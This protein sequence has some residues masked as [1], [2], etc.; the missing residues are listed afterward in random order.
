MG[1][2][3]KYDADVR[4]ALN[5]AR[6]E[7]QKLRHRLIGSEHLLQGIFRLQDPL[8]EGLFA[9]LH[10]SV[11]GVA[12][13][14]DFVIGRGNKAILSEPSLS[15]SARAVLA[16]AE[17][18]AAWQQHDLVKVEHLFL[19]LLEERNGIAAGVLESFGVYFDIARTQL[20]TLAGGGYERLVL[21]TR[22]H[23]RSNTTPVLNQ[24]S[25]DLTIAA[26]EGLIDPLIGRDEELTRIIQILSRR[27][28]NNPALIGPAGVGKTVIAEGLALRI[29]Q[30][31]VPDHLLHSRVVSLD[32]GL[33][34]VGTRFR[35]DFE[36]RLKRIVQEIIASPGLILFIDELHTLVQT[37]V[38]EGSIDAANLFKPMLARGEIRCMGATTLDEYR[39]SVEADPALERRFQPVSIRETNTSETLSIL[40]GLRSRYENFH[41][42]TITD[43]ALDAAIKMSDRYISH[44]CQP[45]KALDLIDEAAARVCVQHSAASG[46]ACQLR[47]ALIRVRR[48]KEQMVGKHNFAQASFLLKQER[49]IRQELWQKE[50]EWYERSEAQRPVVNIHAI[51]D[52]VAMST[53]IPVTQIAGEERQRLLQLEEMLQRR[54]VG[55]EEAIQAVARA[56][57][58]AR[59]QM[60]DARRP[61]GS[62]I[63]VGPT[64]VGKTELARAL[65]ASLFDN[66]NALLKFDMSEFMESHHA[67]RLIGAPPG[68]IG[69]D[70]AGQLTEAVRRRP[71]CVVLFD[72]IEKAH[73]K[74]FDLL[75]QIL[76]EGQL[77]DSQGRVVDF[78][79]TIIILTSNAGTE[80]IKIGAMTF[81]NLRNPQQTH[82]A[83]YPRMREQILK[84]L[85]DVFHPEL[86]NRIDETII[87]HHL[88]QH[89]LRQLV[90]LFIAGTQQCLLDRSITLQVTD[91]ARELLAVH[92]YD[93]EF[94][95]R[96]LRR[97]VQRLLDDMLAE[98]ILSG[99][100]V[101]GSALIV[102]CHNDQLVIQCT[103]Q[104][105]ETHLLPLCEKQGDHAAA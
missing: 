68:Y 80:H 46:E 2:Y 102:D 12:Q 49:Q 20:A 72:E 74:V 86:L 83:Q 87:F 53:G 13:A 79:H 15:G 75:L 24:V 96:P 56:V 21:S 4:R 40:N 105:I 100:I 81:T 29:V 30:G 7:A 57:R 31:N 58:R 90:D 104:A 61:I 62:F 76:D 25:R 45:D 38:A 32:V 1:K 73:P 39:K 27:T 14:L 77:T 43:D 92:G 69:Y 78:R 44:R 95:A 26:L 36:E 93:A 51:A 35:G 33:L 11:M 85:D 103:P 52:I 54:I 6:E 71:Y 34:S 55:Q 8:I 88:E 65:A 48:E 16:R 42:V 41:H 84:T 37:G 19:A 9:S 47:D 64:G 82:A 28:K 67:S 22:F 59:V 18:N 50:H 99:E 70:Q 101:P 89:H 63:F 98:A 10:I 23:A 17:E 60:R 66:E 94:G 91:S 97:T 3:E 5:Y